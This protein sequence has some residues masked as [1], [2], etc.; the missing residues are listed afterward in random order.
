MKGGF[1]MKKILLVIMTIC[2]FLSGSI[3]CMKSD[4]IVLGETFKIFSIILNEDRPIQIYLPKG[5]TESST[6]DR[7]Y[8]TSPYRIIKGWCATGAF[9]LYILFTQP[10][11][12]N[13]YLTSSPYLVNEAGF[14]FELVNEFRSKNIKRKY[15]L[16]FSVGGQD[17]PDAKRKV[18]AFARLLKKKHLKNL[19]WN[20]HYFQTENHYTIDFQT[21]YK[22]LKVLFKDILT[23]LSSQKMMYLVLR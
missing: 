16:Y 7:N 15:F 1:E 4:K 23:D 22:A 17:R 19:E 12:F 20:Y 10:S 13:A 6:I 14:I 9:C 21:L 8:R 5:Y 2:L 18:P 11:L 3:D